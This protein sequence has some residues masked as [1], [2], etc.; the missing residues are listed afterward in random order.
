MWT[1]AAIV[2]AAP[3]GLAG[4]ALGALALANSVCVDGF[5]GEITGWLEDLGPFR[6]QAGCVWWNQSTF[7]LC[8]LESP[9]CFCIDTN[10]LNGCSCPD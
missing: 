5:V 2:G 4:Q 1:V 7:P 10:P 3:L 9:S 8:N 6:V